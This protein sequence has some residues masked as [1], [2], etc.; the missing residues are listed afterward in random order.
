MFIEERPSAESHASRRASSAGHSGARRNLRRLLVLSFL[1]ATLI[2][3]P[4]AAA[5]RSS[6]ETAELPRRDLIEAPAFVKPSPPP[7][8]MI[9]GEKIRLG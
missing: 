9:I 1:V 5:L 6:V 4:E 3:V 7:P 8:E 2:A